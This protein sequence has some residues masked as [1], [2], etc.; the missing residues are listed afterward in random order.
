MQANSS[1][2]GRR[3]LVSFLLGSLILSGSGC[4]ILQTALIVF[5]GQDVDADYDGLKGQRVAV[6]CR[7]R[8]SFNL[9]GVAA[10]RDLAQEV[11]A[12]LRD[13]VPRVEMISQREVAKWTDLRSDDDFVELGKAMDA[14]MVV[15]I[16]LDRFGLQSGATLY[17]GKADV[18]IT[19]VDVADEGNVVW[20]KDLSHIVFPNNGL[21][22]SEKPLGQFRQQFVGV[23]AEQISI[24]FY[25]HDAYKL[26]ANDSMALK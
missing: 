14:D 7:A 23:L 4:G 25:K 22:V 26:F 13:N 24:H 5:K 3:N 15:G 19:V 12:L 11:T 2:L 8:D 10:S 20:D 9:D 21:P 18:R 17:Q 1:V 16:D 6:V